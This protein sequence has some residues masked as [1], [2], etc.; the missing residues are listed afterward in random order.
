[1]KEM[2]MD[3]KV[4][5]RAFLE[6]VPAAVGMLAYAA[7]ATAAEPAPRTALKAADVTIS[8]TPYTPVP[9]YP[10]QP[11]RYAE[12]ALRDTFWKPKVSTNAEVT[13]PFEV[14]KL[15][16]PGSGRGLYGGVLEA[17]I[18]S[19][20]THH[21]PQL[22]AQVDARIQTLKQTPSRGNSGFEIAVAY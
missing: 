9:D 14:Q 16:A 13:I 5:R 3:S 7:P 15:T 10:I 2:G 17:A 22:Q 20:Q 8:A 12:V 18:L 11:K 4:P 19:L 6:A 1:M 21:D